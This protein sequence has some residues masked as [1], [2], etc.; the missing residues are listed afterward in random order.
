MNGNLSIWEHWVGFDALMQVFEWVN[1]E[2]S[3]Q[4]VPA[5]VPLDCRLT[6]AQSEALCCESR[7]YRPRWH[8]LTDITSQQV[9]SDES[10]PDSSIICYVN[11]SSLNMFKTTANNAKNQGACKHPAMQLP[12]CKFWFLMWSPNRLSNESK[13]TSSHHLSSFALVCLF[14]DCL[15]TR[16]VKTVWLISN[17]TQTNPNPEICTRTVFTLQI[18]HGIYHSA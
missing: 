16:T 7:S 4:S 9:S 18:S 10:L 2:K 6:N 11:S 15:S 17:R 14:S 1:V 13:R 8:L 5:E 12:S 3:G